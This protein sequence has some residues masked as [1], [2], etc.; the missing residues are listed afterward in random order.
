LEDAVKIVVLSP[1]LDLAG[2]Y[3]YPFYI[4]TEEPIEISETIITDEQE[5]GEEVTEIIKGKIDVFFSKSS[6]VY[7]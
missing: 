6:Y 4:G 2:L 1:L 3:Q 5:N 7:W